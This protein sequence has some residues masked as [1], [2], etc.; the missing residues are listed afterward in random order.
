VHL[1][2]EVH[3]LLPVVRFHLAETAEGVHPH[4]QVMEVLAV[5]VLG[6][7]DPAPPRPA[8]DP[9]H[10]ADH[11]LGLVEPAGLPRFPV[12]RDQEDTPKASVHK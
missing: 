9:L 11:P 3:G 1:A 12:E 5:P 4:R 8:Q 7:A 6:L 10:F 2:G